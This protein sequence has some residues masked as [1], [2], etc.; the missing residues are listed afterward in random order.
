MP[1]AFLEILI[2]LSFSDFV[3]GATHLSKYCGIHNLDAAI[4][5]LNVL[6]GASGT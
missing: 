6:Y 3:C 4:S 5:T 1:A 2:V